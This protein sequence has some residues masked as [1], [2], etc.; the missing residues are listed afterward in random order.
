MICTISS[1]V[2][3][4]EEKLAYWRRYED[5]MIWDRMTMVDPHFK[6]GDAINFYDE[7]EKVWRYGVIV[8]VRVR[9][10]KDL[11]FILKPLYCKDQA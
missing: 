4:N 2:L 9:G 3:S 11:Y 8:N 10:N 1:D 7:N 6:I 5:Y